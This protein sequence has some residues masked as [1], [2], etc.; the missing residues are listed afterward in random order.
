[1]LEYIDRFLTHCGIERGLSRNTVSAYSTDLLLFSSFLSRIGVEQPADVSEEHVLSFLEEM[2]RG[3]ITERSR[4]RY[5]SSLR[6]FFAYLVE[7]GVLTKNPLEL[8]ETPRFLKKLPA[9]LSVS[10]VKALLSAPDSEKP[11]ELRDRAML[12]VLYAAGLRASELVGLKV[13]DVNDEVG[14]LIARGK[15]RKERIVPLGE[16]AL[17]WLKRYMNEVRP[18]LRKET[19]EGSLFLN[20]RGGPISRQ[21]FWRMIKRYALR[22]GIPGEISPHTIRH[23][24][25]T[26]LLMGG[27]DLRSVQAML[28]HEDVATTE[29]YTHIERKRLKEIHKKYHPRS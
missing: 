23:S 26:H 25:A 18:K 7:R 2:G 22:A 20:R 17:L 3:G 21:Y 5:L 16:E 10:E 29:I 24:F 1:M 6:S 28:G 4:A 27:A 19:D 12:E 13:S 8:M 9:Y 11:H 15:G 14:Y